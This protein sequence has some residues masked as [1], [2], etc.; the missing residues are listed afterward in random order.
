MAHA[1]PESTARL[2]GIGPIA[3]VHRASECNTNMQAGGS[4]LGF[5][6]IDPTPGEW[7]Q[8][9]AAGLASVPAGD[10]GGRPMSRL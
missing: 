6:D 5:S 4:D 8:A 7:S 1:K 10:N 2:S 3:R 9:R